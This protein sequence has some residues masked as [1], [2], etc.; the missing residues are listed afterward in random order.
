MLAATR[1]GCDAG[2]G[3]A[4][5]RSWRLLRHS[6][7]REWEPRDMDFQSRVN[8][9]EISRVPEFGRFTAPSLDLNPSFGAKKYGITQGIGP[10]FPPAFWPCHVKIQ[11]RCD[12]RH[13]RVRTRG[14]DEPLLSPGGFSL[15]R[16]EWIMEQ[17]CVSGV[18]GRLVI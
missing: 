7:D 12:H 2:P 9:V 4:E 8:T 5:N 3:N 14:L 1:L 13:P 17:Y 18:A 10:L 16:S 11:S 6:D 15:S